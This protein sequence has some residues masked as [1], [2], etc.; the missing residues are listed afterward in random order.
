MDKT[1]LVIIWRPI[2][3][4]FMNFNPAS[5]GGDNIYDNCFSMKMS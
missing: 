1:E 5:K 3:S 4:K 2:V